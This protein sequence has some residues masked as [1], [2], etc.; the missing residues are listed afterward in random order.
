LRKQFA[1]ASSASR[2]FEQAVPRRPAGLVGT[3]FWK[4]SDA[5]SKSFSVR[6][7]TVRVY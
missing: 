5:F 1:I 2:I 4:I 3:L 7:F 6:G